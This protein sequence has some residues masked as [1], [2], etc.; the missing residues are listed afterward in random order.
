M[1][2]QCAV[3]SRMKA[4]ACGSVCIVVC[5]LT[6]VGCVFSDA[7]TGAPAGLIANDA[8]AGVGPDVTQIVP[9]EDASAPQ[10]V[11]MDASHDIVGGDASGGDGTVTLH[12]LCEDGDDNNNDG[13]TDCADDECKARGYGCFGKVPAGWSVYYVSQR[14][15]VDPEAPA[16]SCPEGASGT[17]MQLVKLEASED[18][19]SQCT[20]ETT[21]G[22]CSIPL[23]KCNHQNACSN[24]QNISMP[25]DGGCV[26]L[27]KQEKS[28]AGCMFFG[29]SEYSPTTCVRNEVKVSDADKLKYT[30]VFDACSAGISELAKGCVSADA[31]RCLLRPSASDASKGWKLCIA[32]E[33]ATNDESCPAGWETGAFRDVFAYKNI[34]DGRTCPSCS[35]TSPA[36]LDCEREAYFIVYGETGCTGKSTKLEEAKECYGVAGSNLHVK[37]NRPT[38]GQCTVAPRKQDGDLLKGPMWAVCCQE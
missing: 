12:E 16:P 11:T 34:H 9:P 14:D 1:F 27:Y 3:F 2:K 33:K 36:P 31:P 24:L 37:F 26:E 10:D 23:L 15:S 18:V 6:P 30:N 22:Y 4:F 38:S 29:K 28:N 20:C 19:C 8:E 5:L 13:F 35:C 21:R 17:A 7:G 32:K 25:A